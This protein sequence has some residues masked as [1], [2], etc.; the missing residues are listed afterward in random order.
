MRKFLLAI[1]MTSMACCLSSG[2][3]ADPPGSRTIQLEEVKP[4]IP[5]QGQVPQQTAI[6]QQTPI[7]PANTGNLSLQEIKP[8]LTI[9]VKES[10]S[11]VYR[12]KSKIKRVLVSDPSI[13]EAVVVSERE[14]V[15]IGKRPGNVSVQV[16]CEGESAPITM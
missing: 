4:A 15:L 10:K 3:W 6:P 7:S 14:F 16:W 12:T 2:A 5:Q 9:D 13:A 8:S 1:F 11:R